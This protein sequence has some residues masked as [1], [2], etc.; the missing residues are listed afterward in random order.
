MSGILPTHI[1]DL[2]PYRPSRDVPG[3]YATNNGN[4]LRR[5]MPL[6]E[7][8]PD[9]RRAIAGPSRVELD[10]VCLC[11]IDASSLLTNNPGTGRDSNAS[12][13][14]IGGVR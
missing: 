4:G 11:H 12:D 6:T 5:E 10:Q 2:D 3:H 13:Q 8:R 7:G 14:G 9:K 1:H